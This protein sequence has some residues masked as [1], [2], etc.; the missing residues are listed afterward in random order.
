MLILS[1]DTQAVASN[2]AIHVNFLKMCDFL[3][4]FVQISGLKYFF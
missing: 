3:I 2:K 1:D 4:I